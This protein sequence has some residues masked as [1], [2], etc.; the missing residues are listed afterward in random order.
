MVNQ[1]TT[2]G[3][4]IGT[5]WRGSI[6]AQGKAYADYGTLLDAF[7][8]KEVGAV[9]LG[10]GIVDLYIGTVSNTVS[11]GAGIVGDVLQSGVDRFSKVRGKAGTRVNDAAKIASP[12]TRQQSTGRK[13]VS[14]KATA[15]LAPAKA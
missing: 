1:S 9:E 4:S 2:L 7:A 3:S 8:G 12:E 15:K 13:K 14:T 10:R 5:R 6:R 11:A